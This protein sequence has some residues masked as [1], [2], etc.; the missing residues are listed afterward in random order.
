MLC[1]KVFAVD[2]ECS[3]MQGAAVFNLK[4]AGWLIYI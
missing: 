4:A 3:D 1:F 2:K